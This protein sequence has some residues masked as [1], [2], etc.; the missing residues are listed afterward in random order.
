MDLD[1]SDLEF[2]SNQ[3]QSIVSK[4]YKYSSGNILDYSEQT[5]FP[6]SYPQPIE[7]NELK[8]ENVPIDDEDYKG[9]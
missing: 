2:S 1:F 4:A 9:A 5:S 6:L 8:F 3:L 7:S